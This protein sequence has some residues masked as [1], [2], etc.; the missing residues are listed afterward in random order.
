[1]IQQQQR[2]T[3]LLMHSNDKVESKSLI[4]VPNY[5]LFI[6]IFIIEGDVDTTFVKWLDDVQQAK[7]SLFLFGWVL[8]FFRL[9]SSGKT[10]YRQ[11][12]TM[13]VCP[14][15]CLMTSRVFQVAVSVL[16][17]LAAAL[18][19]LTKV[20]R[21]LPTHLQGPVLVSPGFCCLR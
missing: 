13:R 16:H 10:T 1:M 6:F 21:F 17:S 9:C 15:C 14:L 18:Q 5:I 19:S 7:K 4:S 11:A 2:N 8:F 3:L 12:N 20:Y